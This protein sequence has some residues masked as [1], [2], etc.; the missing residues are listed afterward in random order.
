MNI[1]SGG[2]FF[3]RYLTGW[4]EIR[5]S[6]RY[7]NCLLGDEVIF[8]DRHLV[9]TAKTSQIRNNQWVHDYV[10]CPESGCNVERMYNPKL[11]GASVKGT[12]L[13][14]SLCANRLSLETD[15]AGE[16]EDAWHTQPVYYAGGGKGYSGQPE[17]GDTQYLFFPTMREENRYI[18]GC[19]DAGEEKIASLVEETADEKPEDEET[20][21]VGCGLSQTEPTVTE[22]ATKT[23][24][25]ATVTA[26]A[27]A[28][29]A[30]DAAEDKARS[31]PKIKNWSTP[32]R[33]MLVLSETGVVLSEGSRNRV[34][35]QPWGIRVRSSGNLELTAEQGI[36]G[37]APQM[38]FEA[39]N[40]IW[41]RSGRGGMLLL[42]DQ[43]QMSA[44][45]LHLASPLSE[46]HPLRART[47]VEAVLLAYEKAKKSAPVYVAPDGSIVQR[48][49]YDDILHSDE[50]YEYFKEN[51][52]NKDPNYCLEPG[53]AFQTLYEGWLDDTYGRTPMGQFWDHMSTVDGLQDAL[54]VA[55]FVVDAADLINAAIYFYHG[56][57]AE[58]VLCL[59]SV[60]PYVGS[61]LGK[62]GKLA[63]HNIDLLAKAD[64]VLESLKLVIK[65]VPEQLESYK[66]LLLEGW[67]QFCNMIPTNGGYRL[68]FAE[69]YSF[70]DGKIFIEFIDDL[71]KKIDEFNPRALFSKVDEGVGAASDGSR[72]GSK[73]SDGLG[74]A[75]EGALKGGTDVIQSKFNKLLNS[76]Y[77]KTDFGYD[78]SEIAQDFYDAA[79]QQGKIYRIEGK[80]GNINGYEYNNQVEYIYHEVYSDGTYIYDP[81][82]TNVPVLKDDYFRALREINPDGFDVFEIME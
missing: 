75:A 12:V 22:T 14:T 70:P 58:G 37:T 19:V 24:S 16:Q 72:I 71:G 77:Y 60:I 10:L 5:L 6:D 38:T 9:I 8:Q 21:T 51:V 40:Y 41:L 42:P 18:L 13:E 33:R 34:S 54:D 7:E 80:S 69:G 4:Y 65:V 76:D 27:M 63:L 79:G 55:G 49:D 26:P 47:D 46:F 67:E 30:T 64:E 31:L 61:F 59:I 28:A 48:G 50:M 56:N 66:K 11:A 45:L 1:N 20:V 78:C 17:K 39:K 25:A 62:G 44:P 3:E 74:E 29:T 52:L 82:Y 73:V 2:Y 43:I 81:R 15:G 68:C 36:A 23:V 35:V 57:V 53:M 32:G